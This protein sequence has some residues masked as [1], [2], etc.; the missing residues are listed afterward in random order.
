MFASLTGRL[1]RRRRLTKTLCVIGPTPM[2][3][4]IAERRLLFSEV[5]DI[6][7]KELT[8][9][10]YAPCH[11]E[12]SKTE[13]EFNEGVAA[14]IVELDGLPEMIKEEIFGADS[15]QAVQLAANVDPILKR[16][17]QKYR[18]FFSTGEDYFES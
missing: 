11:V 1:L 13:F 6:E 15:L 3:N 5:G 7:R 2:N 18:F 14:C 16:L 12:K 9:R 17:S 8:V 10:I 4:C